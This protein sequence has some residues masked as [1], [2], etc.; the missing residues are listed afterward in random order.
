MPYQTV[1]IDFITG[2]PL[3]QH[4]NYDA[5]MT[6]TCKLTKMV[7][8]IPLNWQSSSAQ[9]VF[10]LFMRN[11]WRTHGSPMKVICDRDVRFNSWYKELQSLFGTQIANT[12]ALN[13]QSDG[14]SEIT[15]VVNRL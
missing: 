5:I 6:V 12:T 3:S 15:R 1:T 4:S 8:L 7:T 11:I 13:P 2:L 9:D 14:Q 10:D